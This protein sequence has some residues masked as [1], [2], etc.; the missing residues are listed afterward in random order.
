MFEEYLNKKKEEKE[1]MKMF[2]ESQ[3][4]NENEKKLLIEWLPY[5]PKNINLLVNS[6]IDGNTTKII[7]NKCGGKKPTYV[8]IKTKKGYKLGGYTTKLWEGGQIKDDNA[9]VFS[10]N[11]KKKYSILKPEYATCFNINSWWGFGYSYNAIV[12]YDSNSGNYV[13]NGTYDIKEQYELNGGEQNFDI[14]SF[15]I[16]QVVY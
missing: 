15:E 14:E 13:G 4:I 7:Q 11:N 3:I 9:F 8:V 5:K 10:L 6:K 1:K 16:Y 2:G 12:I